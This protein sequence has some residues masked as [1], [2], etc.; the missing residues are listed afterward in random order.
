M[1]QFDFSNYSSQVFWLFLCF[2]TLYLAVSLVILPR[3]REIIAIRKDVVDSDKIAAKKI[4]IRINELQDKTE[5]IQHQS[6]DNYETKLDEI[7]RKISKNREEVL[8]KLKSELD[9]KVV[10]SRSEIKSFLDNSESRASLAINSLAQ[11]IKTKI[12]N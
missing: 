3:I 10:K 4:Q 2:T 12:L 5:T 11:N 8:T 1:P 6:S 7:S 9:D